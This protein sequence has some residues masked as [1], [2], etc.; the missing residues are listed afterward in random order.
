MSY[1]H[2]DV[3]TFT[4]DTTREELDAWLDEWPDENI[5]NPWHTEAK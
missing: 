4:K 1:K 3:F 2:I 5:D